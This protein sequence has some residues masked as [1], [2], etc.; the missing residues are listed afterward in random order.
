[1]QWNNNL[2]MP[3][4]LAFDVIGPGGTKKAFPSFL[5]EMLGLGDIVHASLN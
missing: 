2:K 3:A 4:L 1:M 5:K